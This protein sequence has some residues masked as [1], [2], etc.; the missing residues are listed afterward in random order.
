MNA[1]PRVERD[2]VAGDFV[3]YWRT[4]KYI[5]GV[6]LTG[7]RWYGAGVV[8]GKI[9]RNVLVFH[10][11]NM[12][13]VS[14]EH[15]RHASDTERA[16]AQSDGRELLGI[17]DLLQD[18]KN[19]LGHQYA[20]LSLQANPPSAADMAKSF[21][22]VNQSPDIWTRDGDRMIRVHNTLR[23]GMFFPDPSDPELQDVQLHD[24]R[25]TRIKDSDFKIQDTPWSMEAPE[26]V[27]PL[28]AEP[29]LGETHF[30]IFVT[31]R[32]QPME[33]ELPVPE[34]PL[35][36]P[37]S[38]VDDDGESTI[39]ASA[40]LN[41][42]PGST[43]HTV[44]DDS[45]Y[46]PIR[47]RSSGSKQRNE[48][49]LRPPGVL[50]EDFQE[51]VEEL[52][53]HGTKR[54]HSPDKSDS[55]KVPRTDEGDDVL[56]IE[57]LLIENHV[58][59]ESFVA[60]FLQKKLQQEIPH[61]NNPPALQERIDDAKVLEFVHTLQNEK[62]AIKVIPPHE[63]HKIRKYKKDRIMSSR[64]VITEKKEDQSTR[65]KA[66][67]VL[68]GHDDPDLTAKILSG[69]CHS[70]TLS[71][72][73]RSVILQLIVS[74]GWVLSLGDIKGAFLE[75][76]VSAQTS[77][78]PVYSELPPGGVPGIDP[79]SLVQV[80]GNIYGSNDAPHNWYL[81]FD[82]TAQQAGFVKSKLDSGS[83]MIHGPDGAL[84]GVLGAHV[85]D[86]ITGGSG[87]EYDAAIAHLRSRFPFRKW[88]VREGE[89]LGT[90]YKQLEN[91]EI[92][93]QQKEYAQHI[94]PIAISKER[95]KQPW[96]PATEKEVAALRAVN[97]ALGWLSSQSRP[98]LA[99]QT[100]MS[101]QAFPNPTVQHL[102][103]AN[104][105]VR[106]C[107]QQSDLVMRV[108]YVPP[109]KLTVCFWSDA[110][111]ANSSGHKTQGGWV[112]SLTSKDINV[113]EDVPIHC[114]AWKSY[115][116]P[117]VVSST[118][119]GEAQ[120]YA[121]ASGM[122]EWS[123]LLL[124][125]CMD[126]PFRLENTVEVLRRR[127]P[128]GITDC[129]SLYDHLISLGNGGTLDDKR[130]AIDVAII[131]QSIVRTGLDPRWVPTGHMI[132]DAMTK[133]K[134]EAKDLLRSVLRSNRYQ[135]ADED[136]VLERAK[137]E[138][139]RRKQLGASKVPVVEDFVEV[140]LQ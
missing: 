64:F 137:I 111:F 71:Q 65:T 140:P 88:R 128:I 42:S 41:S 23:V 8:M 125:E 85:D 35:P 95:V 94:R 51:L 133:D 132:A 138:R 40:P 119:S 25:G 78:N 109:E 3:Y 123:L 66:R 105:A 54:E 72:L 31:P 4:Q 103:T 83:Y 60:S 129:R 97:G 49:L 18:G 89:F 115:K 113:G 87:A 15:L 7:G 73:S 61:S 98:D 100:S 126:G 63:A 116:L 48:P 45:N 110:A 43:T 120:A 117:R 99:V 20:D 37:A 107:K 52:T 114:M 34:S 92:T 130:T 16:V 68:R 139:D 84:Q 90:Q 127:K 82:K 122:A 118:L 32:S 19:L 86:T 80:L 44:N 104:Q 27:V 29:W 96:L 5:R 67:W 101:Q 112:L 36:S 58:C 124:A 46:G 57:S 13:K 81:E 9:G 121:A 22:Q 17:Q 6:R 69:K 2:F 102:L 135:L 62:K 75:A 136:T 91:G 14:P 28:R 21:N 26:R 106:R 55:N 1:R 131:R 38:P 74:F 39:P 47:H 50:H 33:D 53:S 108:P 10:R 30:Q 79:G 56:M 77:A 24:W 12:F 59:F 76:D 134:A 93:Y 11:Q 70:P